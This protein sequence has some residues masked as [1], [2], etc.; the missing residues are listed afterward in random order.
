MTPSERYVIRKEELAAAARLSGFYTVE[1]AA[2]GRGLAAV[3]NPWT[4]RLFDGDF[5]RSGTLS[6][7]FVQ[8]RSGNTVAADPSTLGGARPTST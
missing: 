3:G 8:S 4:R 5:Y 2:A 7:V 6:L 1:D